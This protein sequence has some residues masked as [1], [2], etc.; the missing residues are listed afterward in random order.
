MHL[1]FSKWKYALSPLLLNVYVAA[2][3]KQIDFAISMETLLKSCTNFRSIRLSFEVLIS[4]EMKMV[5]VL[6]LL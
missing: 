4:E 5:R 6:Q 3:M 2:V 1:E